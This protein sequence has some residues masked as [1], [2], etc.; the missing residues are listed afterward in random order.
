MGWHANATLP[1]NMMMKMKFMMTINMK[2]EKKKPSTTL[3]TKMSIHTTISF[4]NKNTKEIMDSYKNNSI[5]SMFKEIMNFK[6]WQ[7]INIRFKRAT[8]FSNKNKLKQ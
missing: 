6:D 1:R 8:I 3:G 7:V 5:K 2:V 4:N